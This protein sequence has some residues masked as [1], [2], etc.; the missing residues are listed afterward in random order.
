ME[1]I[2]S[3]SQL[4]IE[5]GVY[6]YADYLTW[7]FDQTVELIKG[8]I[9]QMSAP[10]RRHQGMSW[11]LTLKIGNHF[12]NHK[13]KAYAAPFDVRLYDKIKSEKANKDIFTVIQP[14]I[15]IICD[16]DKLDD[17]GCL[18]APDLIIE[19]LSPGNSSKEMKI[20]KML[21]E[22]SGVREY[23]IFDPNTESVFQFHLTDANVYSLATI[24]VNDDTL[25]SVI[26]PDLMIDLKNIFESF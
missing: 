5:N 7:K 15:C 23:L 9:L 22:E 17:K 4:D 8:K 3:L 6:S 1:N 20:K 19:I 14:D 18:G 26:F 11:Q 16:I 21:Y 10:S 24:Y 12:A 13:C 2:V 25:Q